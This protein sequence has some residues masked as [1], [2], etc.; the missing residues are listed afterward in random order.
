M[1]KQNITRTKEIKKI[2]DDSLEA[3]FWIEQKVRP[4]RS[5]K[6]SNEKKIL[7]SLKNNKSIES[8]YLYKEELRKLLFSLEDIQDLPRSIIE[9]TP[10]KNFEICQFIIHEKGKPVA[11][12][13]M[14]TRFEK[15][16]LTLVNAPE[17]NTL[18]NLIKK[19]KSKSFNQSA[20]ENENIISVGNF[21]AKEIE[22]KNYSIICI[23]SSNSFLPSDQ[24]EIDMF[25]NLSS[26]LS[27]ILT[28]VLDKEKMLHSKETLQKALEN[29]PEALVIKKD[30]QTIFSNLSNEKMENSTLFYLD[31]EKTTSVEISN[32]KKE[33]LSAELYHSQRVALL[34]ELLNTLQHELSNPLFGLNLA[35]NLLSTETDNDETIELLGEIALSSLRSQTI[36]KNFSNLYNGQEEF[37]KIFLDSFLKEVITLT[38]SET[39]QIS[40]SITWDLPKDLI[41][42]EL[43]ILT[44]PTWLSQIIFNLIINSA[45]AIKSSEQPL[46][47]SFINIHISASKEELTLSIADNGPGVDESLT[48]SIFHPF[49]TT[50]SS[51]TGLGLA[52]C[53][54][55]ATKLGTKIIL[56]NNS[57]LL[58]A[59]FSLKLSI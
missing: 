29:F 33:E 50:K 26:F 52:I 17:F 7:Q 48:Q 56:K 6:S 4:L 34:G 27:P 15:E 1:E 37:K 20:L 58:G 31:N 36:I 19:S 28:K 5:L 43:T 40:K 49:F 51:G 24:I 16:K 11:Q 2:L 59:T 41:K 44:N 55:L 35:S 53:Q 30:A 13:I 25:Q 8:A 14:G 9:L 18:F 45:E 38:K 39:K 47:T 32:S 22:L 10:F 54:S 57:P 12:N 21:L 46:S 23:L 3:S 42:E